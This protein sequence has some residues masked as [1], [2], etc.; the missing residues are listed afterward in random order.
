LS[1]GFYSWFLNNYAQ[2]CIE[3]HECQQAI[4]DI[5]EPSSSIQIYN[6]FTVG[7]KEMITPRN[8]KAVQ[9]AENQMLKTKSPW[10]SCIAAWVRGSGSTPK[11]AMF[12]V[13]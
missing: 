6:L 2:D 12:E 8:D 3:P 1:A 9:A 13:C 10:T 7:S 5:D 4:V 11:L